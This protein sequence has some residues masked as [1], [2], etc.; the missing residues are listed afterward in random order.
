[1][2]FFPRSIAVRRC[3]VLMLVAVLTLPSIPASFASAY[4]AHPKLVVVIVIDQFRGDYLERYHEQFGEGGFRL[5]LDHGANFTDCNYGYANTRTAP[6]HATLFTGA[7]SNGHG[8]LGNEWWD[9]RKKKMVTAVEDDDT[10]IVGMAAGQTGASPHNLLADTLGDELKLATQGQ[11]RVFSL[12]LKDRAAILSGGFAADAAYWIDH[13]SG[14]WITSTYY[15]P[16]L[17]QWARD[18]NAS[19]RTAKYWDRNWE[20]NGEVLRSTAHRKSK[21]G[22]DAGF[23]EVVGATPF[24]DEYGFEFAKELVVYENLGAGPATD[25]LAISLSPNDILGHQTGPDSPEMAAMMLAMDRELADFFNFLGHRVGLANT[26]IALSADHGI[27]TLPNVAKKFRIPAANLDVRKLEAQINSALAAKF[28]PGHAASYIKF[29]YPVAWLDQDA[30]AAV[31]MKEHDAET[32]VGEA[33]KQAG[34]RSYFTKSQLAEG[35][36]RADAL[37]KKFLNSYSPQGGWYVL[38]VP[39]IYAVGSSKGTDH[40]SPYTYDTHVPL[41]FYGLPFRP[42]TYRTHAEPV[43]LAATFASLLGINAPTHAVGRVL[44]EAL[45]P[46][47][48][49]ENAAGSHN[50]GLPNEGAPQ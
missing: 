46:P 7:Y 10:K 37:G 33:M 36:V 25:L 23:Y 2:R 48:H 13:K 26:W 29:D 17:P 38:G 15:R 8:I 41:A 35:E 18:F 34:L 42:G 47:H 22:S 50:A 39:E 1:M 20:S 3:V 19:N 16:D 27:S 45:A 6:G 11:A 21:D 28:S 32:A 24:A 43:D 4:N 44:T 49:A 14:A 12:S 30:F 5:F 40:A 9:P 31:H